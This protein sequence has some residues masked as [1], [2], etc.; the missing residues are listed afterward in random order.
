VLSEI[1]GSRGM[2]FKLMALFNSNGVTVR[3]ALRGRTI[4]ALC[5]VA[6][7]IFTMLK[8]KFQTITENIVA[9]LL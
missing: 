8:T 1:R 3:G 9:R 2:S 4:W 6:K 7:I 5:G